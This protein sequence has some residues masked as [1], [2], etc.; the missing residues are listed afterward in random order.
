MAAVTPRRPT[1]RS[2]SAATNSRHR[3]ARAILAPRDLARERLAACS[4]Y[5]R[6]WAGSDR[7]RRAACSYS[8]ITNTDHHGPS[9]L[10]RGR[11]CC[12]R[13]Q[14][15]L[16]ESYVTWECRQQRTAIAVMQQTRSLFFFVSSSL[17]GHPMGGGQRTAAKITGTARQA[18]RG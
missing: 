7:D 17:Q 10:D 13:L 16:T 11:T 4:R 12:P 5:P 18:P 15:R 8:F 1:T 2:R 9:V 3:T 6:H 14:A